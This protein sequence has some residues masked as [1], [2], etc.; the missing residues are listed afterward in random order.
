MSGA[1]LELDG[2]TVRYGD[3]IALRDVTV[4]ADPGEVVALA[5]PNG[6]GKSTLLRAVIGLEGAQAGSIRLVGDELDRL[7]LRTRARRVGW[8]PQEEPLGDNLPVRDYVRYGRFPHLGPYATAGATD[9]D[10]VERALLRAGASELADR[11]VWE[12]SGGERQRVRFARVLAQEA[13]VLLL[14]EPTAH[15]DIG[16]QLDLLDR[17][18][19]TA[20]DGRTAVVVA[21]HDLNL[22]ARFSDRIVVLHRG[23]LAADGPPRAILSARLLADVWGI[24]SELRYDAATRLPYLIPQVAPLASATATPGDAR[25]VRVHV[26]AGGGSGTELLRR[27]VDAGFSVSAGALPLFDSDSA[28]V[29]EL[30]IPAALEVPFAPISDATR[31]QVRS[32]VA[33]SEAVVVGPFPVGPANV[34]NLEV[35]AESGRPSTV[36]FVRQPASR[37][38]DFTGGRAEAIRADLIRRGAVEVDGTDDLLNRLSGRR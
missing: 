15:L 10:A 30:R 4:R 36:L 14:D 24:A 1:G 18:R 27:L 20:R 25:R 11:P 33:E 6:S 32:F 35:L 23:R 12:L 38:W 28:A 9:R 13:T 19:E 37:P 17:V 2:L 22:A 21:L 5:G 26:M 16:H 3:R 29:E 34:A 8:M 31:A 7:G